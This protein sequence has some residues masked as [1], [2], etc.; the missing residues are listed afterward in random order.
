MALTPHV[1]ATLLAPYL[2]CML[3]TPKV[4][5]MLLH[6]P[7]C[8]HAAHTMVPAMLLTP[9]SV[10]YVCMLHAWQDTRLAAVSRCC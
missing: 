9:F 10:S 4:T 2:L 8:V 6:P 5:A 7:C 1:T 3:S